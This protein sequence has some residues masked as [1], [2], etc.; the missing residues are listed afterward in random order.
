MTLELG[1]TVTFMRRQTVTAKAP[2]AF[3][4]LLLLQ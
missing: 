1:E 4:R 2:T 3:Q